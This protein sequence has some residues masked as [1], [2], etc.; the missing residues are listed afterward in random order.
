MQQCELVSASNIW[1]SSDG[2]L[3]PLF[4]LNHMVIFLS[5]STQNMNPLLNN[6][7]EDPEPRAVHGCLM[8]LSRVLFHWNC[9]RCSYTS[10]SWTY[11]KLTWLLVLAHLPKEVSHKN[12]NFQVF[13]KKINIPQKRIYIPTQQQSKD[14]NITISLHWPCCP[15]STIAFTLCHVK[16]T[17]SLIYMCNCMS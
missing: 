6:E 7:Q 8:C 9:R 11:D 2:C 3:V 13:L 14:R 12:S 10:R 17:T 16:W 1:E 5:C 15:V 4:F